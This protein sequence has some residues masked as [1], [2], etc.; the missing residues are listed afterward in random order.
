MRTPRA[1]WLVVATAC[2]HPASQDACGISCETAACPGELVCGSNLRCHEPTAGECALATT[3]ATPG[4]RA[5]APSGY[6]CVTGRF[7]IQVCYPPQLADM[8]GLASTIDTDV[9][10]QTDCLAVTTQTD[11]SQVCVIYADSIEIATTTVRGGRPLVLFATSSITISGLLDVSSKSTGSQIGPAAD[12][13]SCSI[14]NDGAD[15]TATTGAGGGA[16]GSFGG[17]GG[18]GGDGGGNGM[19]AGGATAQQARTKPTTLRGGCAGGR[20]GA[21]SNSTAGTGGNGGGAVYLWTPGTGTIA[22]N[23]KINAS[24]AG[25]AAG[26]T[27]TDEGGGGGGSGGMIVLDAGTLTMMVG[28]TL[29]A[30][31][32]GGGG[33]GL[34]NGVT[35]DQSSGLDPDPALPGAGALG[36]N[37]TG[38]GTG[39]AGSTSA[40]PPDGRPG[41]SANIAMFDGGGGGGGGGGYILM[42]PVAINGTSVSPPS[43]P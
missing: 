14:T 9:M 24:G 15:G 10:D 2:Y 3:D 25:G 32:G 16:G 34:R 4:G 12:D 17:T 40:T 28:A 29:I 21:D 19:N 39:G 22:I 20:G 11:G 26:T 30:D 18:A 13:A 1:C 41:H 37:A 27:N 35:T 43:Q 7:G 33:G 8:R 42:S 5:D 38:G 31:G 36:G 23:G 6:T